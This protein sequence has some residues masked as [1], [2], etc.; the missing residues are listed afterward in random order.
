MGDLLSHILFAFTAFTVAGWA[1]TWLDRRWVAV[2][3]VGAI[4]PDLDVLG[5]FLDGATVSAALGVPFDWAATHTLGGVLLLA[6]ALALLFERSSQRRRAFGL[7]VAGGCS[8]LLIDGLKVWA[9][10]ANGVSLYPLTW[11]RIAPPRERVQRDAVRAV[12]PRLQ[13]VDQ[14]M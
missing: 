1:V 12:G 7:L 3:M 11:R 13:P 6:A 4:L 14:E 2:G 8:H 9:D 5:A 10:G